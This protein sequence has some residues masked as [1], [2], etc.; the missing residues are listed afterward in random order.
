M[1]NHELAT[2]FARFDRF[3][4]ANQNM[5]RNQNR[6][7]SS[8]TLRSLT[9][10]SQWGNEG[11]GAIIFVKITRLKEKKSELRECSGYVKRSK[12]HC[13]GGL[14]AHP[15]KKIDR[16]HRKKKTR[17]RNKMVAKYPQ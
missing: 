2:F 15:P 4:L 8:F 3:K 9:R 1:S 14:R 7:A 6:N 17:H 10:Q 5:N 11:I 12:G 16:R 13:S